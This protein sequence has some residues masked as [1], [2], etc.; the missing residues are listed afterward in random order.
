MPWSVADIPNLH[1]KSALVTGANSGIGFFTAL[2]LG[3][4]GAR[5]ILAC[6]DG[7]RAQEALVAM[8]R[9]VPSGNFEVALVDMS[10]IENIHKFSQQVRS[11]LMQLDILVNNAGVM[12]LP[13][14]ELSPDLHELQLATNHLGHFA[15][16]V[17]LI[18]LLEKSASP[19]VVTVSSI[20]AWLSRPSPS[21]GVDFRKDFGY[22]P[23]SAYGESKLANLMFMLELGRRCPRVTSVA[24]HPGATATNLHSGTLFSHFLSWMQT[25][26][27]GALPTLRAAT[28]PEVKTGD[29][30]SPSRFFGG[31]PTPSRI[32]PQAQH[33][34]LRQR[35]WEASERA[36]K[37]S[38]PRQAKM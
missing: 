34:A 21:G 6:R 19:R 38:L 37:V 12:M 31:P 7:A 17:L 16:T 5:V 28:S 25:P 1:G 2:E 8:K 15:L 14:R 4:R 33:L 11:T 24:A 30:F 35:Y 20:M 29:Y 9:E 36:T 26:A 10:S 32:P 23:S 13:A 18:P 3:R 27:N 22:G